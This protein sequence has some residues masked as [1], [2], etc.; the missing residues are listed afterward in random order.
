M[1]TRRKVNP[2]DLLAPGRAMICA[3]EVQALAESWNSVLTHF[4]GDEKK[5]R[6]W[7]DT[8][9]PMLGMISPLAMVRCG[10][11]RRLRQF[12]TEAERRRRGFDAF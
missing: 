11:A 6:L 4:E 2:M 9:N 5:T 10:R 8:P 1:G 7:F 3:E 12:V